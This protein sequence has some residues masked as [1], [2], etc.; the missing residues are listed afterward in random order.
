[1]SFLAKID[2]ILAGWPDRLLSGILLSIA[3]FCILIAW[4]GSAT[5]KAFFASWFLLP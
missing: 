2:K 3:A 4:R 1:M 5:L